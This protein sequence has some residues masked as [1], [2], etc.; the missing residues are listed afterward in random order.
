MSTASGSWRRVAGLP[1]QTMDEEMIVVDPAQRQVHLLNETAGRVWE[2][3]ASP[4]TIDEL[5]AELGE[6]Y[7]V[8]E[9]ELR[10]AVVELVQGFCDKRL[11]ESA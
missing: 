8:P 2:L 10:R 4:R 1:F 6:E 9:D 3:C 5:V 7:E 11:F